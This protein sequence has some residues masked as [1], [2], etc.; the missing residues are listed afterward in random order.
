MFS[1]MLKP[2]DEPCLYLGVGNYYMRSGDEPAASQDGWVRVELKRPL[3]MDS[4]RAK[5]LIDKYR[6]RC[7]DIA[8]IRAAARRL[9]DEVLQM[10]HDG[11]I[12]IAG[13]AKNRQLTV[14]VLQR[15]SI[16]MFPG[17]MTKPRIHVAA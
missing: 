9:T 10:G 15:S 4:R 8:K 11:I 3:I 12:A 16:A 17:T 7:G 14:V 2:V 13:T 5:R 6:T 1:M